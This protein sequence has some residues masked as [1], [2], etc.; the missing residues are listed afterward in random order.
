MP[1][2]TPCGLLSSPSSSQL[3]SRE[4]LGLP[5]ILEGSL[6]QRPPPPWA[7]VAAPCCLRNVFFKGAGM[8]TNPHGAEGPWEAD[9][10]SEVLWMSP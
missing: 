9:L 10:S 3:S 7:P 2:L 1:V 8:G 5:G 6:P 4:R